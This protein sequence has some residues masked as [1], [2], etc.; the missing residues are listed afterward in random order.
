MKADFDPPYASIYRI[1]LY[2]PQALHTYLLMW[3]AVSCATY[4]DDED[5][6]LYINE[7]MALKTYSKLFDEFLG[8]CLE[9][10]KIDCIEINEINC[11]SL[12]L[13]FCDVEYEDVLSDDLEGESK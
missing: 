10:Q 12:F 11:D 7:T 1:A 13:T 8:D 9:L 5:V 3:D 2:C 6:T 4:S